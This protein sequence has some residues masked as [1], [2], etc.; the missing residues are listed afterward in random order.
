MTRSP[1]R[2][3]LLT[4]LEDGARTVEDCRTALRKSGALGF[5]VEA[6]DVISALVLTGQIVTFSDGAKAWARK[7]ADFVQLQRGNDWGVE[8]LAYVALE[9]GSANAR[10]AIPAVEGETVEVRW[11]DGSITNETITMRSFHFTVSDHGHES[12][13]TSVV[14]G[15]LIVS[16]GISAWVPLDEKGL[17]VRADAF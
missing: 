3:A 12:R 2:A 16:R 9:N 15:V 8:Y 14:P 11:P 10:R 7:G 17:K 4:Y 6:D 1:V 5:G 13:G